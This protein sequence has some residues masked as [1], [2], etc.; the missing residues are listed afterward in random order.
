MRIQ[1]SN[2]LVIEQTGM[3]V[4][5]IINNQKLFDF[6]WYKFANDFGHARFMIN[7]SDIAS[8]KIQMTN[9]ERHVL[10]KDLECINPND[11][12]QYV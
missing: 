4:L 10:E 9:I 8:F 1:F 7:A 11:L 2:G 5:L 3:D 6:L 12:N